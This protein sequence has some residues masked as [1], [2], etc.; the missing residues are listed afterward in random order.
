LFQSQAAETW[1]ERQPKEVL[2][3]GMTSEIYLLERVLRVGV[4]IVSSELRID[5]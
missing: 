3:L 1:K 5:L 2:A 4:V